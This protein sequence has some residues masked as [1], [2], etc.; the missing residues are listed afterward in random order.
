MSKHF[1][2]LTEKFG[3][4]KVPEYNF[5]TEV[6]NDYVKEGIIIKIVYDG[7]YFI[8][9]LKPRFDIK[10][11]ID[12]KKRTTEFDFSKFKQYDLAN[13]DLDGSIWNS[14]SSNNFPDKSLWYYS[15]LLMEN[16]EILEGKLNK[17]TWTYA[18]LKKIGLK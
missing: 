9:V 6:H 15:K 2:F 13:L 11:I 12:G 1:S 18:L 5:V 16:H 10:D 14:V 8:H 17:L 7:G 4:I 3:F